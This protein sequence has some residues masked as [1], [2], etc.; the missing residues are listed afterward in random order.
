MSR[1]EF[2]RMVYAEIVR[3]SMRSDGQMICE[4]CGGVIKGKRFHVDHT[5]ADALILDKKRK[6][7]SN[8]G[9]VLGVDCCHD[10]KTK[11]DV[12]AIAKAKRNEAKRIGIKR[13]T[14]KLKSQGFPKYAKPEKASVRAALPPRQLFKET[15]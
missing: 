14:G 3:R 4:G 7:T 1:R 8:D 6:L 13:P 10:P 9:R 2:S 15:T 12:A 5:I 11:I